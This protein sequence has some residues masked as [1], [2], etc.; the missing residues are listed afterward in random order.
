MYS[1]PYI[2]LVIFFS[3]IS[4]IQLGVPFEEK[5]RKYLNYLVAIVFVVFYGCR[6]FVGWDWVNYYP[7]FQETPKLH[8]FVFSNTRFDT[9][10]SIYTSLIKSIFPN[11][12][13]F[14][15]IHTIVSFIVLHWFFK[16]YLPIK[17]YAFAFAL[18]VAIG[19]NIFEINLMRNLISLLLF[20]L[21][22]PYIENRKFVNFLLLNI[23]GYFFHWSSICFLPLYF[24][25][26]RKLDIRYIFVLFVIGNVIYLMQLEYIKPVLEWLAGILGGVV[27]K[28]TTSYFGNAIFTKQYGVTLGYI[29]RFATFVILMIYY[30][31]LTKNSKTNTI[32]INSFL[33]YLVI[34]LYFSEMNILISRVGNLFVFPYWVLWPKSLTNSTFKIKLILFSLFVAYSV[35]RINRQTNNIMYQ[36]DNVILKSS[37][38]YKER[39]KTYKIEE[40]RLRDK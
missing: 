33:I 21:S 14:I 3:L 39:L 16:K 38:S 31:K 36:Y 4:V 30:N 20:L 28:K 9:G 10:F 19:G 18:F 27:E 2:V 5:S 25:I 37:K 40:K 15:F 13:V 34:N 24:F 7:Y 8:E 12:N 35:I 26:Y 22:I 11:Y 17:Y 32:F 29:E 6:G 23:I 1:T